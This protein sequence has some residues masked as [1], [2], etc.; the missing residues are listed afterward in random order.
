MDVV[1]NDGF[2]ERI[3]YIAR[4]IGNATELARKTGISRR[5]IGT[6]LSG[7]SDPTR[8]RLVCIAR[9]SGVCIEW[10]AVGTGP[11]FNHK[12]AFADVPI[13]LMSAESLKE[14]R[15]D[16]VCVPQAIARLRGEG[17][18]FDLPALE[19]SQLAFDREWLHQ[20]GAQNED[21]LQVLVLQKP[22]DKAMCIGD[23]V[24]M[25]KG[26]AIESPGVYVIRQGNQ[27]VIRR[28]ER[29]PDKRWLLANGAS[30][31]AITDAEL[32]NLVCLGRVLWTASR[33]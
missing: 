1:E 20:L 15:Q 6:Y 4:L 17:D 25:E 33:L 14:N 24:L 5:A 8:E 16:F 7:S 28:V 2:K 11:I 23:M 27:N 26:V 29:A 32:R 22:Y 3:A 31:I 30:S 19:S 13:Q 21:M 10:L 12:R 9:T 18:E